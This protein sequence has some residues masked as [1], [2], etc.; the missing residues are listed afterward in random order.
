MQTGMFQAKL[1]VSRP[2]DIYEQEAD[3]VADQ[4][5]RMADPVAQTKPG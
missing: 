5:M 3:R 2:D 4:V 1:S